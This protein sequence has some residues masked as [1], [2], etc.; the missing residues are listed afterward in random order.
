MAHDTAWST[1]T[2]MIKSKEMRLFENQGIGASQ[3]GGVGARRSR[4]KAS[5]NS[6]NRRKRVF[7]FVAA[8]EA[9]FLVMNL[10]EQNVH[11]QYYL[12][13]ERRET[14]YEQQLC[15]VTSVGKMVTKD[16]LHR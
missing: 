16:L 4:G 3:K 5:E 11:N 1:A 13:L 2:E 10:S 6:G 12:M 8:K 9:A 14:L 15:K 7:H